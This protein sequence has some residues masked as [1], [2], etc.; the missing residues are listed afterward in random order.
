MK[1]SK[2]VVVGTA[3]A[4]AAKLTKGSKVVIDSSVFADD[5]IVGMITAEEVE[6]KLK[7]E[8]KIVIKIDKRAIKEAELKLTLEKITE[9]VKA[10]PLSD[11][12]YLLDNKLEKGPVIGS[13]SFKL[14]VLLRAGFGFTSIIHYMK[15]VKDETVY[16]AELLRVKEIYLSEV[17]AA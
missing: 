14:F 12:Q 7:R 9:V 15:K 3:K 16:W 2:I 1:N 8:K 5:S 13:K 10:Q 11:V 4:V 17:S 6:V